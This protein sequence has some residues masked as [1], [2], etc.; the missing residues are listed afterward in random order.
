[1]GKELMGMKLVRQSNE[2]GVVMSVFAAA[3]WGYPPAEVGSLAEETEKLKTLF[4]KFAIA[5][6]AKLEAHS[7]ADPKGNDIDMA[8]YTYD[9]LKKYPRSAEGNPEYD[10]WNLCAGELG[11][12]AWRAKGRLDRT[13]ITFFP[14]DAPSQAHFVNEVMGVFYSTFDKLFDVILSKEMAEGFVEGGVGEDLL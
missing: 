3:E 1:M 13:A 10:A 8:K 6:V 11:D 5:F 4:R 2:S 12:D 14:H 9:T 7:K